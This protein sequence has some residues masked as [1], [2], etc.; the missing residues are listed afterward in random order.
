MEPERVFYYF[1]EICRIP[2][3]SG[4]T[5]AISDYLVAF[6][7]EQGLAWE[8]DALNNVII[9]KEATPGYEAAPAVILQGHM[10]MVCE[11]EPESDLDFLRDG[12]RL[13]VDGD[14]IS[15]EGTTLGGDDGIA[16]AYMLALLEANDLEHPRL[17]AVITVDEETGMFGAEG[18]DLSRLQGRRMLNLDSEEE[19]CLLAGCAGGGRVEMI[20]PIE[21]ESCRG[22]LMEIRI[23]G[24]QGGHSGSEIHRQRGNANVLAGRLIDALR[25]QGKLL[26]VEGGMKDNAI[27]RFATVR[28]VGSEAETVR[29]TSA[30]WLAIFR[31]ELAGSDPAVELVFEPKEEGEFAVMTE[32]SARRV[33]TALSATP[34]GVQG[35]SPFIEGLV[36]TS[37]NLG[38]VTTNEDRVHVHFSVRSSQESAKQAL[39]RKLALIAESIGATWELSGQ[40]PAWPYRPQSALREKMAEVYEQMF[41]T[42]PR[43]ETIHAGL[44]CGLFSGKIPDLDCVSFGP[45]IEDIHTPAERLSITSTQRM[46]RYLLQVLKEMKGE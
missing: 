44:E 9:T 19:G 43:I 21:R 22:T 46:W 29:Q 17:E 39:I 2:H 18:I 31:G 36:E 11:K 27:P 26:S 23:Q 24:L 30:R 1:E 32:D 3:G 12:L 35:M 38:I 34:N 10:D 5:K 42:K 8:Q 16:V 7:K 6:A 15:A 4:N 37:D 14:Y 33:A 20:L 28:F 13:K 40:Y 41:G 25:G 45:R